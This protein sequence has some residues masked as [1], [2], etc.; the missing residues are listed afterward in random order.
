MISIIEC[1][2]QKD[3][4]YTQNFIEKKEIEEPID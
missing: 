3:I 4:C 1:D 2:S